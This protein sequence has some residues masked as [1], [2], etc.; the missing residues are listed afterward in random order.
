MLESIISK[1]IGQYQDKIEHFLIKDYSYSQE[2]DSSVVA[3][4]LQLLCLKLRI[5]WEKSIQYFSGKHKQNT[6]EYD[7][8]EEQLVIPEESF[9]EQELVKSDCM[10]YDEVLVLLDIGSTYI[11]LYWQGSKKSMI[12]VYVSNFK[13]QEFLD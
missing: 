12:K 5:L 8:I 7:H 3:K 4:Q 10:G 2:H 13:I 6:Q 9:N 11:I 1:N